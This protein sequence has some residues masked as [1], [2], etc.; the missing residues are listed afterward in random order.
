MHEGGALGFGLWSLVFGLGAGRIEGK[1][2]YF[3]L[4]VY[5]LRS[6]IKP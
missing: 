4:N 1:D 5:F 3:F 6:F 2:C